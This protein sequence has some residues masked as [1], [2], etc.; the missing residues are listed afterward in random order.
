MDIKGGVLRGEVGPALPG[1][2]LGPAFS[3][4]GKKMGKERM[5][6]HRIDRTP[7]EEHWRR[8]PGEEGSLK[9]VL[10]VPEYL[11]QLFG[12]KGGEDGIPMK[13]GE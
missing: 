8:A 3:A 13:L 4:R 10:G 11:M 9:N 12:R 6:E 7:R 1:E 5:A 2:L